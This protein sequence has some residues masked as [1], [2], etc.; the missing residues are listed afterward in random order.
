MPFA[1]V[2]SVRTL[3]SLSALALAGCAVPAFELAE[4]DAGGGGAKVPSGPSTSGDGGM[5]GFGTS[6]AAGDGGSSTSDSS[7]SGDGGQAT[8]ASSSAS[9]GQG[10]AEPAT[11]LSLNKPASQSSNHPTEG[12]PGWCV[13]GII[14]SPSTNN[15]V[16]ITGFQASAWWQVDLGASHLITNVRVW[17]RV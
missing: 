14:D 2:F 16:C 7:S 4:D 5:G 10:G 3:A 11:L 13:D 15:S 6:T 1:P 9:T 8:T 17:R 12:V